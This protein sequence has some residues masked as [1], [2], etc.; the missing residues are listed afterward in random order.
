MEAQ[1]VQETQLPR[2]AVTVKLEGSELL[3]QSLDDHMRT[4]ELAKALVMER[5]ALQVE[6]MMLRRRYEN[7]A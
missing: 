4:C 6:L 3:L 7:Q 5:D 1:Q 2:Y